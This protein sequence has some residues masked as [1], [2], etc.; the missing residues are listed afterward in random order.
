MPASTRP[1]LASGPSLWS[2]SRRS[3]GPRRRCTVRRRQRCLYRQRLRDGERCS[4]P[5]ATGSRSCCSPGT[6]TR[7][8]PRET[9]PGRI[10]DGCGRGPRR[11]R[12]EGRARRDDRARAA[13][14]AETELAYDLGLLFFPREELGPAENPLPGVFER[15]AARRRGAARRSASSR[16]TTRCSSAAS[17]TSTRASSSKGRR[18]TRRGRG[19]AS[20]RSSSRSKGCSTVLDAEPRDVDDRRPG[21]PR[22]D[23][24][25]AAAR[26]HRD[27]RRSR[28]APRR[29]QL[30]LRAGPDPG[31]G[32]G[33]RAR[34]RRR[35][36]RDPRPT[37][38][39]RTSR[40]RSPLVEQLRAAGGFE[41]QPKQA[42]TNVADFAARGLDAV[43]LG[44]GAT[45]YAHAVDERVEIAR[46]RADA[47]RRFSGSCS[48][49][50]ECVQLSPVLAELAQYPFA[51]LD[52]WKAEARGARDR[53]DRLRHGRSAR[54]DA[55][56]HPRGAARV[57]RRGV[58]VPARDRAAG[59][60][61]RRSPAGSSG[62]SASTVDPATRDRADAR[63]EGGDLLVRAGRARREAR[64]SRFP[65]PR[66]RCT[67]AARCSRAAR[68][69]TVPLRERERLAAR[70]RRVRRLGRDR[71]LLGLLPEQPD[72]RRRAALVL[73]GARR[74]R[75]RA[76]L[77]ALLG[78]GVLGAL[79]R[80][81]AGVGA[82]GR[83]PRRTSSSSTRCR[84]ARR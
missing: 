76:R 71:A 6:R 22:G 57:G 17:A 29:P 31:R 72:R 33:A 74:A 39:R 46:A 27:E 7:F 40:S 16:P 50:S 20:T 12:H 24:G 65:S 32:R 68:V 30:P 84:S 38:R 36:R 61:R 53:A 80:R 58:V 78:R 15:A 75:A 77:P 14:P 69:V 56:V 49:P 35:R 37:R 52:D 8:R 5:S 1:A 64:S 28:R 79:V 63:L 13:G 59:A 73:R 44:P 45:R 47:T 9:C 11:E 19:S 2:T 4:T 48:V 3:R 26:R 66:I 55:G 10:E 82:A 54:G 62:A 21:L 43:N 67:S 83:G 70:P 42:W 51:R 60:A 81:A 18:R 25:H 34:A 41:V 23:L